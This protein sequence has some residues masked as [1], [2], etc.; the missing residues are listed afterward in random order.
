ME[1]G[2]FVSDDYLNYKGILYLKQ[3]YTS[4]LTVLQA[5]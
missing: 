5:R 2:A 4:L 3:L 1:R